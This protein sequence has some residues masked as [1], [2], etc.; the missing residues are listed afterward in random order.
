MLLLAPLLFALV[1]LAS[2]SSTAEECASHGFDKSVVKCSDCTAMARFIPDS[3][4]GSSLVDRCN[5]CCNQDEALTLYSS[6]T[7]LVP[8]PV[9]QTDQIKLFIEKHA[10]T[11]FKD[12]LTIQVKNT[13][14]ASLRLKPHSGATEQIR[15]EEWK[16]DQIVEFITS[17]VK[18][19]K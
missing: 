9:Y 7:L 13:P 12:I 6:A 1:S 11:R 18:P 15:V 16:T 3:S 8:P 2:C 17:R 4:D 19:P 14:I 5:A 10:S